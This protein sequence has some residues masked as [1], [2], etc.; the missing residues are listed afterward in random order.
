MLPPSNPFSEQVNIK[1]I[2]KKLVSSCFTK[3]HQEVHQQPIQTNWPSTIYP[4]NQNI[5]VDGNE[6][7]TQGKFG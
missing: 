5:I 6:M 4:T 2:T 3:A 1:I 7:I